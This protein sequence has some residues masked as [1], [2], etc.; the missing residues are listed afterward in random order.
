MICVSDRLTAFYLRSSI[1]R[2]TGQKVPDI[3]SILTWLFLSIPFLQVFPQQLPSSDTAIEGS[4]SLLTI[5]SADAMQGRETGTWGARRASAFIARQME[6]T[7][8][9]P[10]GD[11]VPSSY[12]ATPKTWF[13]NFTTIK[14]ENITNNIRF[15]VEM[16]DGTYQKL[17]LLYG[18]DYMNII[19]GINLTKPGEM[20]FAGFGIIWP[21]LGIDDYRNIDCRGKY[22]FT[23]SWIGF[24]SDSLKP[25]YKRLQAIAESDTFSLLQYKQKI[26]KEKG[27]IELIELTPYRITPPGAL[28]RKLNSDA[29]IAEKKEFYLFKEQKCLPADT[30]TKPVPFFVFGPGWIEQILS[31][32][33]EL[34]TTIISKKTG[35]TRWQ[36]IIMNRH[37]FFPDIRQKLVP[38]KA[39][40]VLGMI[41]GTDTTRWVI[42]GAHYDHLGTWNGV[43][44]NGADDNASGVAGM[45]ALASAWRKSGIK[46]R[47]NLLFA[48]WDGEEAGLLGSRFFCDSLPCPP[49]NILHYINL[50]MI[51]RSEPT[52]TLRNKL[53]IKTKPSDTLFRHTLS[54]VNQRIIRPFE[55]QFDTVDIEGSSDYASFSKKEIPI[56]GFGTG[57][58]PDYHSPRDK[59]ESCDIQKMKRVLEFVNLYLGEITNQNPGIN[60]GKN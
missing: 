40:N 36:P 56:A 46:P 20:V 14:G 9:E 58:H 24:G 44:F 28:A 12:T 34:R 15:S 8:L 4:D 6:L 51:S 21:E 39:R 53:I 25:A 26:A 16:P 31:R 1:H 2:V 55:L 13:Q 59:A 41:K 18:Y 43:L 7:G 33:D 17:N 37:T 22:V 10:A 42:I 57:I 54:K 60:Q 30:L 52:D 5:L 29:G 45:L 35:L 49:E 19:N 11:T 23:I 47:V 38:Q 32:Y 50:D 48:A 3:S 27:A